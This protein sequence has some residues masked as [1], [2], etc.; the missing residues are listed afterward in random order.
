MSGGDAQYRLP[1]QRLSRPSTQ[2]AHSLH[3]M[4]G[5]T[6]TLSPTAHSHVYRKECTR[7]ALDVHVRVLLKLLSA[8]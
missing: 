8:F 7:T 6:A 3:C 2:P 5:S 4:F 1:S